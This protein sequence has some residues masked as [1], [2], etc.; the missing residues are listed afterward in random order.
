M[1][2]FRPPRRRSFEGSIAKS[3]RIGNP[4]L[5]LPE[6]RATLLLDSHSL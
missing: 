2:C 3:T 1:L 5:R 4:A 6:T